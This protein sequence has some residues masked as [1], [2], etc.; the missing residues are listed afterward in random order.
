LPSLFTSDSS[1]FELFPM[2]VKESA[3]L[4]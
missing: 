4:S 2:P 1:F 3:D